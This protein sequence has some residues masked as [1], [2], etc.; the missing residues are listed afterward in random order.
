MDTFETYK[1]IEGY[2]A[3]QLIRDEPSCFNG[4]V[5]VRKYKVSVDLVDEPLDVIQSRIQKMWDECDNSHH[6]GQLRAEAHNYGLTLSFDTQRR[7]N[8]G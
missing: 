2:A 7:N 5:C 6:W 3:R 8:N 4:D 1:K